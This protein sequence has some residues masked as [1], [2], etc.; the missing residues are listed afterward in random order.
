MRSEVVSAGKRFDFEIDLIRFGESD[1]ETK[2]SLKKLVHGRN[3]Y[4][5]EFPEG[6]I[7]IRRRE[8]ADA[9]LV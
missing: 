5:V 9:V 6:T 7:L 8:I 3:D 4:F 1:V 2:M